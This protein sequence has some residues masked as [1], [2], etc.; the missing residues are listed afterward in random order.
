MPCHSCRILESALKQ[1]TIWALKSSLLPFIIHFSPRVTVYNSFSRYRSLSNARI[2]YQLRAQ[3]VQRLATGWTTEG[4]EF[5]SWQ[6]QECSLLH[7]TQ[8]PSSPE[9]TEDPFPLGKATGLWSRHLPPRHNSLLLGKV[10]SPCPLLSVAVSNEQLLLNGIYVHCCH[11]SFDIKESPPCWEELQGNNYSCI[12]CRQEIRLHHIT[13]MALSIFDPWYS[14]ISL[15]DKEDHLS[16]CN[17]R[18][19]YGDHFESVQAHDG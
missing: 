17:G 16:S 14:I 9:P 4:S 10:T 5:E 1:T 12:N 19:L 13:A 18:N 8:T 7:V 15:G 11:F 3:S 2:S 6:C